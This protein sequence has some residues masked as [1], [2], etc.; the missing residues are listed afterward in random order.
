MVT[1]N[2]P[3]HSSFV[4]SPLRYAHPAP[5]SRVNGT[6]PPVGRHCLFLQ[7]SWHALM[8]LGLTF[9]AGGRPEPCLSSAIDRQEPCL[10]SSWGLAA[11]LGHA[12][13][14]E[15]FASA[16]DRPRRG[17]VAAVLPHWS[18]G[19]R[20]LPDGPLT[21]PLPPPAESHG[22]EAWCER[23]N[24]TADGRGS[25][26]YPATTA[27]VFGSARARS[28]G[29]GQFKGRSARPLGMARGHTPSCRS[30]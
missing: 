5:L 11:C 25:C 28:Y 27:I 13:R 7:A 20:R 26:A 29:V 2:K 9:G 16:A 1:P 23:R 30:S 12:A 18:H 8:S 6:S 21:R 3:R 19:D 14:V 24:G 22:R 4:S 10:L 15:P 17:S